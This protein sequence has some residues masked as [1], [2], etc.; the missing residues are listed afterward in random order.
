MATTDETA[1]VKSDA[2]LLK[3]DHVG[4]DALCSGVLARLCWTHACAGVSS[5]AG[6]PTASCLSV[7]S[8]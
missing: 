5:C 2:G 6:G 4:F 3:P 1:E 7:A 8:H